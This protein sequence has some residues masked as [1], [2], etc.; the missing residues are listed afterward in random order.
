[1]HGRRVKKFFTQ[2]EW[3]C[4]VRKKG[5]FS[6]STKNAKRGVSLTFFFCISDCHQFWISPPKRKNKKKPYISATRRNRCIHTTFFFCFFSVSVCQSLSSLNSLGRLENKDLV[7]L[8]R[9]WYPKNTL[10]L[11]QKGIGSRVDKTHFADKLTRYY[12]F[13]P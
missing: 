8:K 10:L 9:S 3:V 4:H 11:P 12:Q 6:F 5:S 2:K 1:M 7:L 13:K